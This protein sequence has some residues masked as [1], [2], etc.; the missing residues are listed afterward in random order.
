[1]LAFTKEEYESRLTK[2]REKMAAQGIEVLLVMAPENMFYLSGYDTICPYYTHALIVQADCQDLSIFVRHMEVPI[3]ADT[4][5]A[6]DVHP[7]YEGP[8]QAPE[9]KLVD[10][11][12]QKKLLGKRMGLEKKHFA[13]T[14]SAYEQLLEELDGQRIIDASDLVNEIRIVKSPAEITYMR[15]AGRLADV[16]ME[17]GMRAIRESVT[18]FEIAA[19]IHSAMVAQGSEYTGIPLI[20]GSGPRNA[21]SLHMVPTKRK[22]AQA[23]QINIEFA[24]V[25]KRYHAVMVRTACLGDPSARLREIYQIV[26][27][28][29]FRAL[30]TIQP[31]V[32]VGEV[33]LAAR[34]VID[35]A[36]FEKYRSPRRGYGVGIAYPPTW[37][38]PLYIQ[39]G[40]PVTLQEGMSFFLYPAILLYQEGITVMLGDSLLVTRTGYERLT[41]YPMEIFVAA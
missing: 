17:A 8:T 10:L 12:R 9:R 37:L 32:N 38:E 22:V 29:R 28:A 40:F 34:S 14:P 18:E 11:L 24:G 16:G 25:T 33:D 7:W 2:V 23:D 31:G 21:L 1:M 6:T 13:I 30:E 20:L 39:E 15:E 5:I 35:K 19:A 41:K 27:E 3:V 36:G 4:S 26:D